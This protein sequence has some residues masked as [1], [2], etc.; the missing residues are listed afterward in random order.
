MIGRTLA[1]GAY[2][3]SAARCG[4]PEDNSV[5]SGSMTARQPQGQGLPPQDAGAAVA[6][7]RCFQLYCRVYDFNDLFTTIFGQNIRAASPCRSFDR[8]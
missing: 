7:R 1:E 8:K 2:M 3:E 6:R 5:S 4:L